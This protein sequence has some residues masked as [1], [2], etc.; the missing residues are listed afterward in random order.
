VM[1][2]MASRKTAAV[3]IMIGFQGHRWAGR[4]AWSIS[5]DVATGLVEGGAAAA[6]IG[7]V[8]GGEPWTA[9]LALEAEVIWTGVSPTR[10]MNTRDGGR[11]A[12]IGTG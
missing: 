6:G 2:A 7:G 5:A 4:P 9:V 12:T 11:R 8:T 10:P 1:P 3:L